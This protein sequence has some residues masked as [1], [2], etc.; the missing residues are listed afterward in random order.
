M[1][2]ITHAKSLPS[3][4]QA[5]VVVYLSRYSRK[6]S[7]QQSQTTPEGTYTLQKK[8]FLT[9]AVSNGTVNGTFAWYYRKFYQ[10]AKS[11][12]L[13]SNS[14]SRIEI[15]Q[16]TIYSSEFYT[17]QYT[18]TFVSAFSRTAVVHVLKTTVAVEIIRVTALMSKSKVRTRWPEVKDDNAGMISELAQLLLA[19]SK[20]ISIKDV[21]EDDDGKERINIILSGTNST[22]GLKKDGWDGIIDKTLK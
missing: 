9:C 3:L 17:C 7:L 15:N 6:L 22:N 20:Q 19:K 8:L 18:S 5:T 21:I 12:V 10:S 4:V 13:I 2:V 16:D 1:K 11:D 14:E